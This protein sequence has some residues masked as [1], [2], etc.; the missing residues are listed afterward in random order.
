MKAREY[1]DKRSHYVNPRVWSVFFHPVQ[2]SKASRFAQLIPKF[3]SNTANIHA[4]NQT[5]GTIMTSKN[6][7]PCLLSETLCVE[8]APTASIVICREDLHLH[9]Q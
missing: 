5:K 2:S 1:P 8:H 7:K 9:P 3:G 4:R 6:S